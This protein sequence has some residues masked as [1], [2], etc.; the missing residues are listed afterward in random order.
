MKTTATTPAS[1]GWEAACVYG[2]QQIC[3]WGDFATGRCW[4]RPKPGVTGYVPSAEERANGSGGGCDW[5]DASCFG[6]S[7]RCEGNSV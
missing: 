6:V 5:L 7:F 2:W 3:A 1:S 4:R